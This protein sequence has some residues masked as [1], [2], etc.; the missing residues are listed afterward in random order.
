MTDSQM[1]VAPPEWIPRPFQWSN[2]GEALTAQ[3]FGLYLVNTVIIAVICVL[4]TVFTCSVAAFSFSRLRWKGRNV[5]F[6]LLLTGV[7]L[8]Y[9]VTIIPTFVMWQELGALNTFVP[10]TVPAW[11]AGRAAGCSTCSCCGSSS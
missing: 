3:P 2:F 8:P 4:G 7:M 1:F 11:F 9:A 5:V 6:A 10:L